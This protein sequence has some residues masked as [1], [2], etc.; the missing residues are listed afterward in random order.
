LA[1]CPLGMIIAT[2][3]NVADAKLFF[4]IINT[5]FNITLATTTLNI[6]QCL[7]QVIP[8]KNKTLNI[9]IYTT[10]VMLSNGV[11]P[12]VG[13]TIYSWLGADF[14]ALHLIFWVIFILR[15]IATGLWALRWFFLR[16]HA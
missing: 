1:L 5:L 7:L 15:L 2:S 10:L 4:L 6:L 8:E 12:F 9:S 11:M 14:K 16:K 13:V 3:I